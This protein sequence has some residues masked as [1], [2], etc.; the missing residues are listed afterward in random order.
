MAVVLWVIPILW[1]AYRLYTSVRRPLQAGWRRTDADLSGDL[2]SDWIEQI[3]G[4]GFDLGG[5]LTHSSVDAPRLALFIDSENRDSAHISRVAGHDLFVF[6]TRFADGFA[7]ETANTALAPLLPAIPNNPVFRF[8]QLRL[9][10]DLYRVHQQIK[11]KMGLGR[12]PVIE[13]ADGEIDEFVSRAEVSR[14]YMMSRDYRQ[15]AA[16]GYMFRIRG[17]LR[18]AALL[19]WPVRSIRYAIFR[20]KAIDELCGLGFQIDKRTGRIVGQ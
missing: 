14:S 16:N 19:T 6:E 10:L 7:F 4:L 3:H 11:N 2:R 17:A 5:Y 18:H 8:P 20:R 13:N 12:E 1:G 9:P 15:T